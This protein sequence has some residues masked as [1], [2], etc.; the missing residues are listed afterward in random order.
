MSELN[1]EYLDITSALKTV[2]LLKGFTLEHVELVSNGE[3]TA[4]AVGSYER[5]S[6]TISLKR[7][8]RLCEIYQVSMYEII[9]YC[10]YDIPM[11]VIRRR[12]YELRTTA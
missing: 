6:R 8:L 9:N 11:H 12:N 4:Q 2:R 5:N 1:P 3:F 7:L 10:M